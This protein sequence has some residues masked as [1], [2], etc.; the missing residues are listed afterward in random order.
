[1]SHEIEILE[2]GNAS[3]FYAGETPWHGL[4]TGVESAVTA[5]EAIKLSGLDWQVEKRP[6]YVK[7]GESFAPVK[8]RFE[9]V[10]DSDDKTL[11]IVA[12]DYKTIQNREAFEFFDSIVD[13]GEA[14]YEAAGSLFGGKRIFLTAMLGDEI[15]IGGDD[16]HKL[17]LL[18]TTSHDGSRSLTAATT[19]IRAVCNNTVT[20]GLAS[21]RSNW[22]MTHKSTLKGKVEDARTSLELAF[23]YVEEF[24]LEAQ[25]MMATQIDA[26]K[27]KA[28][29]EG[30]LPEQKRQK[31]KNV[32]NLVFRFNDS[33]LIKDTSAAGNAWGAYNALTE[34]LD[35]GREVRSVEARMQNLV[36]GLGL[37]LRND[38]KSQL[39]ELAN[40]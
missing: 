1:M 17:F 39:L 16:A 5:D 15:T 40:A 36:G 26:D 6:V 3:M 22:T 28:I 24:E 13:N 27:F 11:G 12:K 37:R 14:K 32:E 9:V 8:D 30:L 25:K 35:H 33:P 20:A 34:W 19:L 10:R 23:K 7:R 2:D 4:G 18:L 21:A 31:E 29:V 38:M